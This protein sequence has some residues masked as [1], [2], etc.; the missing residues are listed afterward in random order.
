MAAAGRRPGRRGR[1]GQFRSSDDVVLVYKTLDT[2][3]VIFKDNRPAVRKIIKY[4]C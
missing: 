1:A 4:L 2:V 3:L